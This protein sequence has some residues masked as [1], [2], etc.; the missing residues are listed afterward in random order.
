MQCPDDDHSEDDAP[1]GWSML[2]G[3]VI[4][5]APVFALVGLGVWWVLRLFKS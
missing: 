5:L 4:L 3:A 1:W 2:V